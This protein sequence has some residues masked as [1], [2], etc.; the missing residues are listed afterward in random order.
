MERVGNNL[1]GTLSANI[2]RF[3][4]HSEYEIND[5]QWSHMEAMILYAITP[6]RTKLEER[7]GELTGTWSGQDTRSDRIETG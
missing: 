3:K 5:D 2:H 4:G 6:A 7:T 1:H